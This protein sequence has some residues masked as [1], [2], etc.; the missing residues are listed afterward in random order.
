MEQKEIMIE[1]SKF[2]DK[3]TKNLKGTTA[4]MARFAMIQGFIQGAMWADRKQKNK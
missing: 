1:A 3:A 4:R 2:A